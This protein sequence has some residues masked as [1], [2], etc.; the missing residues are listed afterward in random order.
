MR[1]HDAACG[2]LFLT[3]RLFSAPATPPSRQN[4][5]RRSNGHGVITAHHTKKLNT[6]PA[7]ASMSAMH[8]DTPDTHSHPQPRNPHRQVGRRHL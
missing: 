5:T 6:P 1:E 2:P 3:H 4:P 7:I 8:L